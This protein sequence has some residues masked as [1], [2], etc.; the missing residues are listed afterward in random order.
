VT[1]TGT[2]QCERLQTLEI[3]ALTLESGATIAVDIDA[4]IALQVTGAVTL[5]NAGTFSVTGPRPF[6][7]SVLLIKAGSAVTGTTQWTPAQGTSN[8]S[9]IIVNAFGEVW[10][11]TAQATLIMVR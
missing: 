6:P 7:P 4:H 10:L 5:P 9:R 11:K 3:S 2:L 1:G 8:S